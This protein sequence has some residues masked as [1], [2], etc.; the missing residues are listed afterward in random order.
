MDKQSLEKF[1]KGECPA[2]EAARVQE[3]IDQNPEAFD[4]YLQGVWAEPVTE[5]MPSAMEQ[6]LLQEAASWSGYQEPAPY[7]R[8]VTYRWL[9]WAAAAAVVIGIAGWWLLSPAPAAHKQLAQQMIISVPAGETT[10]YVLPDQSVVWLKANTRLVVDTQQYNHP[11][12]TVELVSGEAFFE[13]Q[14]DAEHPF[15]VK[16]GPVQT[17]VLGTSFSVQAGLAGGTVQVTVATGKVAVSHQDKQLDILLPGKQ[18][19]VKAKTGEFTRNTVPVWLAAA[20]KETQLQLNNAPF[21]ELQLAMEHLYG[22]RLQTNSAAVAA[23]HYN[24]KLNRNT[25]VQKVIQVLALL[26]H[27]QYKKMDSVTWL[28]Y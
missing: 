9:Y 27:H 25:P 5:P 2:E 17:K 15:V 16:N 7:K 28:L 11:T 13:V 22:I 12:R 10:R 4:E 3:W 21:T 26:N 23:Q 19:S 20:W 24:I 1:L 18:I 6:A 14:K 8:S